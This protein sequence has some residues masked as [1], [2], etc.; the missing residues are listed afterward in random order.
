MSDM[1]RTSVAAVRR[2]DSGEDR[3][4]EVEPVVHCMKGGLV[5]SFTK[6]NENSEHYKTIS[7][8]FLG[9]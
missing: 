5:L 4:K 7:G 8:Y 9:S 6:K 3:E 2:I 1:E